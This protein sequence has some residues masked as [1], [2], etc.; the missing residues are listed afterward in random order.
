MISDSDFLYRA[1]YSDRNSWKTS[2]L[3]WPVGV[4][5]SVTDD[6]VVSCGVCDTNFPVFFM[7]HLWPNY[8][9]SAPAGCTANAIWWLST[10]AAS[11]ARLWLIEHYTVVVDKWFVGVTILLVWMPEWKPHSLHFAWLLFTDLSITKPP[12]SSIIMCMYCGFCGRQV[13]KMISSV[14]IIVERI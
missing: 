5:L 8:Y 9:G 10:G 2:L 3:T 6:H 12:R 4:K 14:Y 11:A 1:I 7:S 13:Y